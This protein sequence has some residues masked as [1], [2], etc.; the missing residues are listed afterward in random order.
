MELFSPSEYF[1]L[2]SFAHV[3]LFDFDE[4]VWSS[5]DKIGDYLLAS[6]LGDI[7][8]EVAQGAYL[9]KPEEISIGKGTIVEPGAYIQ[10][11]CIIGENCQIRHGAYIR[12]NV[13]TGN[14]CIIGHATEVKNSIFL[15]GAQAGHFAYVGDSILGNHVNLGAGT[16]CANLR[17]DNHPVHIIWQGVRINSGRRKLGAIF[18][19]LVQTGCNSVTNPG[20]LMGRESRLAPCA[21]A[22]GVV[23]E[24]YLVKNSSEFL[25]PV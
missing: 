10:G 3:A 18:G 19:D 15:E 1:D 23:P 22:H 14:Q 16:K 9:V 20:T 24:K 8:G 2:T 21:A 12:G 4:P 11:P 25:S 17:F 13:I 6:L 5:L 7:R